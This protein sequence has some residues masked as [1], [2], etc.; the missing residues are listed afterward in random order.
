MSKII[1]HY[2]YVSGVDGNT[3]VQCLR[4]LDF[5]VTERISE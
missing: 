5:K 4:C 1:I 2:M 3:G